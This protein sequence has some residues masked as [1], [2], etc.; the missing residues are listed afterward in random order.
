MSTYYCLEFNHFSNVDYEGKDL[1]ETTSHSLF[2]GLQSTHYTPKEPEDSHAMRVEEIYLE[3]SNQQTP[4][5]KKYK[6]LSSEQKEAIVQGLKSAETLRKNLSLSDQKNWKEFV[7]SLESQTK[8]VE[9]T[10]NRL[11][12]KIWKKMLKDVIPRFVSF[13]S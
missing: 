10:T 4:T 13:F 11:D 5:L 9:E 1:E 6:T 7:R 12:S 3:D 2:I 8:G